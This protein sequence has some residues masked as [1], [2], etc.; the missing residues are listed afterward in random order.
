MALR[1]RGF[2]MADQLEQGDLPALE[3]GLARYDRDAR[4]LQQ[5]HF[6]WHVPLFRAGQELLHG[7]LDEA[8]RL[9]GEALAIGRRAHDP[10]VGI[11]H[12]IV[13]VGLRWEQ[14]RLPE[15]EATLRR[16]VDRFPANLGWRATLAVLLCE[17]GRHDE[18]REHLERLA[19][20]DFAGLPRNH[21][22]LYHLA[23]LA[24]T[25]HALGDQPRA[26]RLYQRLLPY[27]DR[28]VLVARL[29]LGT[30][31]SVSQHLG[32]LAATMSRWDDAEAHFRL[33]MRAHERMGAAAL[34]ARSRHDHA[35]TLRLGA[36]DTRMP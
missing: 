18:A 25:C 20:D 21:L 28:N 30:L 23:V 6:S 2:L 27:G 17:A 13:L 35:R 15:L 22:Y 1:G 9:T 29:P 33:A 10:V 16:F 11:Y 7:N 36:V 26:S 24:I 3:R 12:M 19:A 32:L 14:G 31:G 34:L 8:D 5:L 4:A